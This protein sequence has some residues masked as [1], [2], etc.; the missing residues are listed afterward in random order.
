M[1]QVAEPLPSEPPP[2]AT[3]DDGEPI[4]TPKLSPAWALRLWHLPIVAA[5]GVLFLLLNFLPL[6]PTDLWCHVGY[7]QWILAHRRLPAEDPFMPLAQG[8]PV[9]DSAWLSQVIFAAIDRYGGPE[10]LSNTFAAVMLVT[11]LIIWRVLY[12][13]TRS[14]ATSLAMLV[15]V[16][17]LAWSRLTTARPENFA[18]LCF[19]LLWWCLVSDQNRQ[20]GTFRWRLW[21]GVPLVMVAWANLHGSFLVGL[22]VLAATAL[23]TFVSTAWKNGFWP[24][25][26][27]RDVQT[28][29]IVAEIALAAVCINPYGFDLILSSLAFAKNANLQDVLEWQPLRYGGPGGY[30]FVAAWALA[31]LMLRFSRRRVGLAHGLMLTALGLATL[32]SNRMIGW[33]ALVFGVSF[34]PLFDDLLTGLR[35]VAPAESSMEPPT[36]E[37]EPGRDFPLTGRSWNYSLIALL[38]AWI[39][40]SLAPIAQP[41]LGGRPRRPEQ[42]YGRETPLALTTWLAD[43]PPKGLVFNPQWWGDWIVRAGPAGIAPF[44]TSNIHLVPRQVWGDYLR[45]LGVGPGWQQVLGRYAVE[46]VVVDKKQSPELLR[47]LQKDTAWRIVYDDQQAAV[48]AIKAK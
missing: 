34:A 39:P 36:E 17:A 45:V 18:W 24:A 19:A 7:G 44:M 28:P 15:V 41:L 16:F 42:L 6:R 9:V 20:P 47:V 31:L 1:S 29:A 48:F 12:L 32:G 33:F 25:L 4:L 43:H 27:D 23:G 8:M 38:L 37:P 26:A 30:E 2:E 40:L 46:T 13:K 5:W 3:T 11:W 10:W 35:G 22:A 14:A 21:I